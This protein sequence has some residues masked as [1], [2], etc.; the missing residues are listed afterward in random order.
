LIPETSVAN[1]IARIEGAIA[2]VGIDRVA[3]A[4]DG[5][6]TLWTQDIGE[7]LFDAVLHEGM[8]GEQAYEA[9]RAEAE[10]HG[11][12]IEA[13]ADATIIARALF[14]AYAALQYPEDR[15]CA[16]MAWCMAGTS[17]HGLARLCDGMLENSFGL[18]RKLIAE[19]LEVLRFAAARGVPIWLVSAS[20]R[21]VVERAAAVVENELQISALRVIAMTPVVSE[22][23]IRPEIA[24]IWPYGEGKRAALDAALEGRVIVAAMGDNVFDV[25][26][27]LSARVPLAI[28]PKAALVNVS[29]RVPGLVRLTTAT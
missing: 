27:L 17:T 13:G 14:H 2:E 3:L 18:R 22:D 29:D 28:R 16:A 20:P 12:P 24:G 1:A 7:A 10:A 11:L 9:L 8:V 23:V 25:P 4:T 26:M 21:I 6:G 15:M 19:S 5:D